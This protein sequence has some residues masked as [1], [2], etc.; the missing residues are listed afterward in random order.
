ME[1]VSDLCR[2]GLTYQNEIGDWVSPETWAINCDRILFLGMGPER[3]YSAASGTIQNPTGV[4]NDICNTP[5]DF[6]FVPFPRD[7][8]SAEY[9][10]AYDTFGYMVPKGAKNIKGATDWIQ[11]NRV[12]QTDA[13][14]I[15]TAREDAINPKPVY[16][17]QGKY[18]GMQKWGLVWDERVYNV[19][20]DM[21]DPTKFS[22][23]FDDCYGFNDEL[24]NIADTVLDQPLFD[25]A[26]WTQLSE[27]NLPLIDAIIDNYR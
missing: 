25:G 24:T 26:S 11:L 20:Q 2:S 8:S 19:W 17:T 14:L 5:S 7:P 16:Y 10:I 12:Y 6:A 23:V 21:T 13:N 15:A 3:T 27:E 4:E 1:Y 18:E 9:N 22:F